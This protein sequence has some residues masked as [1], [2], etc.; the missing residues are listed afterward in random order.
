MLFSSGGDAAMTCF[1]WLIPGVVE[2]KTKY[3]LNLIIKPPWK[4]RSIAIDL[5]LFSA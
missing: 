4:A 3:I 1:G 5:C 2:W